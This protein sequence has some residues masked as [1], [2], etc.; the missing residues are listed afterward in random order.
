MTIADIQSRIGEIQSLIQ[1][2]SSSQSPPATDS[3]AQAASFADTL[4]QS[5]NAGD[6]PAPIYLPRPQL[7]SAIGGGASGILGA[8]GL[9]TTATDTVS[10]PSS[11]GPTADAVLSLAKK[12]IGVPYVWGGESP[13]GF[14][15][16]GLVQYVFGKLGVKLPRVAEDQANV[17]TRVSAKDAQPGD[18]LFFGSPVH[19]VGI[20]AGNNTMVVA[21]HTGA[22]VRIEQVDPSSASVIRRVLQPAATATA[23]PSWASALP[24]QGRKWAGA[25]SQAA[26]TA[27]VDPKLLAALV[28]SESDFDS[29]STSPVGAIGL[30]QLMP[31][32]A[33]GLGVDPQ[34]PLQN[35]V[36]GARYLK[37]QLN[38]FGSPSL[39]LAA[40]NAGPTAVTK[41]NGVPP[42]AETQAYV[43]QVMSRF[44][45]LGGAS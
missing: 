26:S 45:A 13:S 11:G 9:S 29:S 28:W 38:R 10:A 14:D 15:C 5:M 16:S 12:Y 33:Q 1:S 35:L 25:I 31:G 23:T 34:N 17:G 36:G 27:G 20:Y 3:T 8:G 21:P 24:A 18:L 32:T 6:S 40:Y 4:A 39:A 43:R 42:Y 2:L 37:Q 19:H 22:N 44:S 30:T 41:Y 7:A